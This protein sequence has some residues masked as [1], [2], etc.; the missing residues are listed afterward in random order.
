MIQLW[1]AIRRSTPGTTADPS[2]CKRVRFR[3][4]GCQ[5]CR[6]VCPE[7]A[8]SLSPGPTI[9]EGCLDCG[10]CQTACP[11]E[12]FEDRLNSDRRLLREAASLLGNGT[13]SLSSRHRLVI[14]CE[15]AQR[16]EEP[17]L[18]VPCLGRLGEN[19]L[20]GVAVAGFGEVVLRKGICSECR[21]KRGESLL[22]R[23]LDRASLL[24]N[25]PGFG[26]VR[27]TVEERAKR[28][29][30][31]WR[32]RAFFSRLAG[33]VKA[34]ATRVASSGENRTRDDTPGDNGSQSMARGLRGRRLLRALLGETQCED[35]REV[36]YDRSL[37]WARVRVDETACS[38]C[39]ICVSVCPTEALGEVA[40]DDWYS[41]SF[42]A[43]A[44]TNCSLCEEACV[45]KAIE[46]EEQVALADLFDT[47]ARSLAKVRVSSCPVCGETVPASADTVCM[48]CAK[49]QLGRAYGYPR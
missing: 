42:D 10:L 23:S 20:L 8:I 44:C 6:K 16:P 32:R 43:S 33:G 18:R 5:E 34:S 21:W 49:R 30:A 24:L 41:L 4:S 17:G 40:G 45:E 38:G 37:P 13:A 9:G 3:P 47:E 46:F 27:V 48:T 15:R 1:S 36:P 22:G 31:H 25:R 7:N 19:V 39:R 12:V 29:D 14:S 35:A 26:Q 11:T 2:L 28:G